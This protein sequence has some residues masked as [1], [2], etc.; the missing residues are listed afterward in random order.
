MRRFYGWV[1]MA[2]LC[3]ALTGS[4]LAAKAYAAGPIIKKEKTGLVKREPYLTDPMR[5]P[6]AYATVEQKNEV[7]NILRNQEQTN[8]I[9]FRYNHNRAPS[10]D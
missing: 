5:P 2:M 1:A 4:T 10:G 8:K 7:L 6:S 3:I 9:P